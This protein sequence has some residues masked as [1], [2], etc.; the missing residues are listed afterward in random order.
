MAGARK[1]IQV[2]DRYRNYDKASV[3]KV[4]VTFP[5]ISYHRV[6]AIGDL[7]F[8]YWSPPRN[9]PTKVIHIHFSVWITMDL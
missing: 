4:A 6:D 2:V 8:T 3:L 9:R 1:Y 5:S 7:H